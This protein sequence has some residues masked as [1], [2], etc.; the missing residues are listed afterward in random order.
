[1]DDLMD[2]LMHDLTVAV[3]VTGRAADLDS[4]RAGVDDVIS[5]DWAISLKQAQR[6]RYLIAVR[7][8][9]IWQVRRIRGVE[10][11]FVRISLRGRRSTLVRF[12]VAAAPELTHLVGQQ[13]PTG[14]MRNPV[15]YLNTERLLHGDVPVETTPQGRRAVV[16]G[17]ALTVAENGDVEVVLP[18]AGPTVTVRTS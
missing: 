3:L 4:G 10:S 8:G 15:K 13:V 16:A 12:A 18:A 7:D 1:M 6:L 9:R 17:V 5:G 14:R 11:S 2:D